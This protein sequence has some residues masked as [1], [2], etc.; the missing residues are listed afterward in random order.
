MERRQIRFTRR[1]IDAIHRE[2]RR[3]S[4]SDAAIVRDAVEAWL[5]RTSRA[6][7]VDWPSR[8]RSVGRFDSGASDI[9]QEHDRELNDAFEP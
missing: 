5:A 1:Q 9:G 3:R 4:T 6:A 2:A 7:V 8:A